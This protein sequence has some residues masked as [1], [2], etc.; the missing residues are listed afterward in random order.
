MDWKFLGSGPPFR[1]M[2]VL[3][4]PE[5]SVFDIEAM[6]KVKPIEMDRNYLFKIEVSAAITPD[7]Y[8]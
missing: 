1:D 8:A 5:D 3:Y 6:N 7:P 4:L 2:L